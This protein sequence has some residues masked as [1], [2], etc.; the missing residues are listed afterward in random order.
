MSRP[1]NHEENRFNGAPLGNAASTLTTRILITLIVSGGTFVI[2]M[3]FGGM[4]SDKSSELEQ[5]LAD[6]REANNRINQLEL[7]VSRLKPIASADKMKMR[8]QLDKAGETIWKLQERLH[9]EQ[10]RAGVNR[11]RFAIRSQCRTRA[12]WH[13]A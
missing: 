2:G 3:L 9:Q 5:Q 10:E 7:E 11:P 1:I 12:N 4:V 13:G 8:E 6:L